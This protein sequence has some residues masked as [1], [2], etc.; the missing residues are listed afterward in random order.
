[1]F[2]RLRDTRL[3]FQHA[4]DKDFR[5]ATERITGR[6]VR[7]FISGMDVEQDVAAELS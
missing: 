3:F 2:R 7:A 1:V 5:D 4:R 6:R